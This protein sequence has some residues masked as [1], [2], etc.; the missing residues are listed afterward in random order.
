MKLSENINR[1]FV[2][3]V[4]IHEKIEVRSDTGWVDVYKSHKT[5]EYEVYI[6]RLEDGRELECA[7][8]HIVFRSDMEEVFVK[9]LTHGDVILTDT[10][11]CMVEEVETTD[12][13]ENMYDLEVGGNNR[14]YTNG[15]LSHNTTTLGLIALHCII[16]NPDYAVGIT[17]FTV[18]NVKDVINRIKYTYENL[19]DWL[20]PPVKTYNTSM[21]EFTNN[22]VVYGQVTSEQALRGRTN[23]MVIVDEFAFC[24]PA[25]ADEFY[26]AILPSLTADGEDSNTKAVFISTPNG[27]TGKFAE[28]A[29]SAMADE[30]GFKF[31]E[32]DHTQ[33]PGR[34]EKFIKG[35]IAK[36]GINK[37]RQEYECKWLS[38]KATLIDSQV[39]ENISPKPPVR[40]NKGLKL[41]V[42]SLSGRSINIA[43]DPSEGVGGDNHC[44]QIFDVHS[45]EQIG[46]YTNNTDNQHM[47]TKKLIEIITLAFNEGAVEVYYGVENN[48]V[49]NGVL[50]LLESANNSFLDRATMIS[51]TDASGVIRK[52][53]IS[54]TPKSKSVGCAQLKQMLENMQVTIND[55][56]T[57]VELQFFVKSGNSFKAERGA[58]DDRVMAL[59]LTMLMFLELSVYEDS[60]DT[61]VNEIGEEDDET[62]GFSF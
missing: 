59:V 30:N 7:D 9:D 35:M 17:S 6:L 46:I 50:R 47:L 36:L 31:H 60:V 24:P 32:V 41:F 49:G 56:S 26:T 11:L 16:F 58:K 23:N 37:Y 48:G 39:M 2:E 29:F 45:L 43:V 33:I 51:T 57:K 1:K 18:G 54:M 44:V 55:A 13:Y 28:I 53:G 3:S 21:V 40:D 12:R 27:T 10:G 22:S 14:Y 61:A 62:W 38:S 5:V 42:D 19:A 34:T 20:K 15:I 4:P 25:V 8:D 52:S